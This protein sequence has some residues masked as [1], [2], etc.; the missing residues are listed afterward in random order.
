M[1]IRTHRMSCDVIN[2]PQDIASAVPLSTMQIQFDVNEKG[3]SFP[4]PLY[5][6]LHVKRS[7][8]LRIVCC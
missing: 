8:A 4:E 1:R 5:M 7:I 2:L 6:S 3:K